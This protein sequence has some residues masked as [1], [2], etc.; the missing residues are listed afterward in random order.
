MAIQGNADKATDFLTKCAAGQ[1]RKAYDEYVSDDFRHHNT[2][3]PSDRESLLRGM[4]ESAKSE[5]NKSFV[6]KQTIESADRVA[7]YSHLRR[8]NVDIDIAVVHILRFEN[9]KIVEM[10]DV[11]QQI[12][13][14]SPNKLG[15]F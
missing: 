14:D 12:P 6:V 5:P 9:G 11:G 4:E 8:E 15:M 7:V 1:V 3:F 2:Y 10:W 13:K